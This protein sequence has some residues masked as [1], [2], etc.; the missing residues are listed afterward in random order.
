MKASGIF[1]LEQQNTHLGRELRRKAC[2][3]HACTHNYDI[4]THEMPLRPRS[5][6]VKPTPWTICKATAQNRHPVSLIFW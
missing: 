5:D 1:C 6:R 2:T 4:K 3:G